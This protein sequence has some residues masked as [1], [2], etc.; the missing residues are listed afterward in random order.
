[1]ELCRWCHNLVEA[2]IPLGGFTEKR[3]YFRVLERVLGIQV[4]QYIYRRVKIIPA[5]PSV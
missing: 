2:A 1:M 4:V 5:A 3:Q